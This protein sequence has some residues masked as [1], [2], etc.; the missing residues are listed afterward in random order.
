MK[1]VKSLWDQEPAMFLAVIQ[2]GVALLVSFGFELTGEQ[3]GAIM[4]FSAAVVGLITRSKV[5]PLDTAL[6]IPRSRVPAIV[7]VA[8]L[9]AATAACVFTPKQREV[10]VQVDAAVYTALTSVQAAADQLVTDGLITVETRQ[11]L[12]PYLLKALRLG[13]AFN[14]AAAADAPLATVAPLLEAIRELRE[15]V[16]KLLPAAT[17]AKLLELLDGARALVPAPTGGQ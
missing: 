17:T 15:F 14:R 12:S 16:V 6:T 4:A 2:A 3:V 11:A 9:G 1:R 8:V 10:A 5:T 13:R 7:L